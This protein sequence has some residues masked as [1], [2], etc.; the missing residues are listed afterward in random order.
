MAYIGAFTSESSVIA[1]NAALE[2]RLS[3]AGGQLTGPLT[4]QGDPTSDLQATT[5]AYVDALVEEVESL[6]LAGI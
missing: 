5:K 4:L 2:Q 3:K 6:A 1:L